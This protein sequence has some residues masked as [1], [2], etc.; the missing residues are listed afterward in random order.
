M[1]KFA[2][3]LFQTSY[4]DLDVPYSY[5]HT[6]TISFMFEKKDNYVTTTV[7]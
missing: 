4:L 6:Y 5:I 2:G 1:Q 3:H 7:S